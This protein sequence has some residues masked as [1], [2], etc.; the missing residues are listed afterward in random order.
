MKEMG[1]DLGQLGESLDLASIRCLVKDRGGKDW[2][3][4]SEC[5]LNKVCQGHQ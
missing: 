3:E 4:A 5:S 2:M 1:K